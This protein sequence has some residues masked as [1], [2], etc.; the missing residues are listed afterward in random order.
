MDS[1]IFHVSEDGCIKTFQPRP[2]PS[3]FEGLST[4]VVFGILAKLLH[5]YLLPRDCPRVAYYATTATTD[6]DRQSFLPPQMDFV[7]YIEAYWLPIVMRTTLYCYEMDSR[8]FNLLDECAGYYIAYQ[9]VR[10]IGVRR[11]DSILDEWAKW[12]NIALRIVPSLWNIAADVS[13]SSLNYSLIRM[14]NARP[15]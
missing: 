9:E 11:I 6:A 7:V 14:R 3:P 13:R 1:S 15:Q 4:D 10:P 8:Y 2:S 5:H 12:S